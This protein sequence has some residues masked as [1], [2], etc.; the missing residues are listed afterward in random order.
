LT[1]ENMGNA[2]KYIYVTNS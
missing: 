1:S 2:I